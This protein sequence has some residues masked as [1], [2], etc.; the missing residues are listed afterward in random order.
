MRGISVDELKSV[1]FE[2][3]KFIDKVCKKEGLRYFL[4]GGTLLG[5]VRHQGFIPWDDDIDIFM[6]RPDYEKL[7]K[8]TK[9]SE[10]YRLLSEVD[11]GYYYNFGKLV[12]KRTLLVEQ[13]VNPIDGMGIYIDIFPVDGMPESV[14][15][16]DLHFKKL[17]EIR[18]K[19]N[20]FSQERPHIRKNLLAYLKSWNIYI[21]NKKKSLSKEQADYKNAALLYEYDDSKNVFVTG[22]AYKKK[23][24]FPKTWLSDGTYLEF[25]G[26]KFCVPAQYDKYLKQLYG[27]YMKLPPKEKQVTH[28]LFN[29]YWKN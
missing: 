4:C 7:I 18:R 22:G 15:E 16:C 20:G 10:V 28:H 8:L 3:L 27:D 2:M 19:I 17:D 21:S 25:E 14:S 24:I 5:A 6:P 12:D 23:D 9:E 11:D 26:K 13:Q 1:E 29:A